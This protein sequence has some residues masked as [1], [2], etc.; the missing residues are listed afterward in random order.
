MPA[1]F[2]RCPLFGSASSSYEKV[3]V[4]ALSTAL[5]GHI[6]V[7]KLNKLVNNIIEIYEEAIWMSNLPIDTFV[8]CKS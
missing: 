1:L 5:A 7:T 4:I 2:N 8:N 3:P 6:W